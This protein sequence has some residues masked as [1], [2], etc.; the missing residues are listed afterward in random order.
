MLASLAATNSLVIILEVSSCYVDKEFS[1]ILIPDNAY[2]WCDNVLLL[3]SLNMSF[4][5]QT[6][7][8]FNDLVTLIS[9]AC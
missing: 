6:F 2:E 3:R 8:F 1:D 7:Y 5:E 9:E 4:G